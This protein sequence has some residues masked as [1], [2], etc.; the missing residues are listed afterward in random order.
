M[1]KINQIKVRRGL[2]LI[3]STPLER[4]KEQIP[5]QKVAAK[6][7]IQG[8]I[9]KIALTHAYK[10]TSHQT[11]ETRFTFPVDAEMA[12]PHSLSILR[13]GNSKPR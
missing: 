13:K 3:E 12:G 7:Q 1:R 10:N 5:L 6:V 8:G 2:R 11:I 4:D 9:A